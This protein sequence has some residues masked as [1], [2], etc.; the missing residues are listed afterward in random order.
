MTSLIYCWFGFFKEF[1]AIY[2]W[3][4]HSS[5]AI[6]FAPTII[7]PKSYSL[8]HYDIYDFVIEGD[9][10]RSS[11][12][13][14]FLSGRRDNWSWRSVDCHFI[15]S[16]VIVTA[17]MDNLTSE[18]A[19]AC[20]IP[21]KERVLLKK[22][23]NF[24]SV[25]FY[26]NDTFLQSKAFTTT[27][28]IAVPFYER[29]YHNISVYTMV[30]NKRKELIEWIEYHLLIGI[31][32][33]YLYD[34][35]GT[36]QLGL[37]LKRY[38]ELGLVT[39]VYWP[40]TPP[41]GA[42]WNIIQSASMNHALKN[43]GPFNKWLGYFD[44]DEYFQLN[45]TLIKS[46]ISKSYTLADLFD[47]RFPEH[48]YPSGAQFVNCQISC[49][50]SQNEI[51]A[52]RYTLLFQKCNIVPIH[53]HCNTAAK[54]FIRPHNVPIMQNIHVLPIGM[55]FAQNVTLGQFGQFR[56]YHHGSVGSDLNIQGVRDESMDEFIS[57]LFSRVI[58]Y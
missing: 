47:Y 4:H 24:I 11:Q 43:F 42:H 33:F 26:I 53:N 46:V 16:S 22:G 30:K 10:M 55:V 9:P 28:T 23:A 41:S 5:T 7:S 44:V 19:V 2:A 6:R 52:S 49:F 36:E 45:S 25:S 31:E 1:D 21:T 29:F 58:T 39:I 48:D 37:F 56:H 3:P 54:M 13:G 32:H 8:F 27:P 15:L 40:Y 17:T 51:V 34:N 57:L 38:L 14:I 18:P 12:V 35:R 20:T 50:L